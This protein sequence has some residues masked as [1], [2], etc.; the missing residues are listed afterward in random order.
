MSR[1]GSTPALCNGRVG[2]CSVVWVLPRDPQVSIAQRDLE[3]LSAK[4]HF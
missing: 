4:L 3:S 2:G 1:R